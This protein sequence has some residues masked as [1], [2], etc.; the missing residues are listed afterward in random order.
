MNT[1]ASILIVD[2]EPTIREV[3]RKYLERENFH[4]IEAEDGYQA[5]EAL[6][7]DNPSL[8]LLDLMLPGMDGLKVAQYIRQESSVPIIM[9]TAK[10]DPVD[11]IRGLD[12]GADDYIPKPFDPQEVVSRVRAVLRRTV[13]EV[14]IDTQSSLSYPGLTIDPI[15]REVLLQGEQVSLT[16]K[17]F[18]LLYYLASHPERV[19]SRSQLLQQ[20]WGDAYYTDPSTV[21]V[22][23]RRLREKIEPDPTNPQYIQTV[24]GVGYKFR[25]AGE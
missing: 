19:F 21:T 17:E 18:D 25:K 16:A 2:D 12:M 23:V 20:I 7:K 10:G 22:H 8:I 1:K 6:H 15:K 4:V 24:W 3:V 5:L 9:L 11:R 14:A 13:G